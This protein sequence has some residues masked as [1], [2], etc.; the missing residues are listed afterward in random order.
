MRRS[1]LGAGEARE[2]GFTLLEMIVVLA[3]LS[4][5]AGLVLSRGP[6]HSSALDMR[7]ATA[8]VSSTLRGART[9][10]IARNTPVGVLF[11][12]QAG[13][14]KVADERWRNLPRGIAVGVTVAA[15]QGLTILFLPDGSSTGGRV[16]LAGEGRTA[17]VG[18]D[19]LTGRVSVAEVR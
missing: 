19:W 6:Q 10:A 18:V 11:D 5:V 2:R 16:E 1:E 7:L 17:Q 15:G 12:T 13:T 3:V 4:L 14:M 9:R 8:T